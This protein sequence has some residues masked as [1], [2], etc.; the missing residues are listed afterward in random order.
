MFD[1][2]QGLPVLFCITVAGAS[3]AGGVYSIYRGFQTL[4]DGARDLPFF[5]THPDH[6][7][8]EGLRWRTRV[9]WSLAY[10]I[11]A[12]ALAILFRYA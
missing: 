3:C 9:Y 12:L 10:F 11:T 4:P 7:T 6:I 1:L 5:S 2:L 8:P